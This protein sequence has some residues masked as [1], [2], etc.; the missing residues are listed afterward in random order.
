[1]LYYIP[2]L[3]RSLYLVQYTHAGH[4]IGE[5]DDDVFEVLFADETLSCSPALIED[6]VDGAGDTDIGG[7][8]IGAMCDIDPASIFDAADDAKWAGVVRS[9]G[10][11]GSFSLAPC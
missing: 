10:S 9:I 3:G 6:D 5:L 11:A 1:M 2:E 8:D 4:T 7:G